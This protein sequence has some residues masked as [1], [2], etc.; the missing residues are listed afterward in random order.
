MS[1]LW[2]LLDRPRR[3]RQLYQL[4]S[5]A[6]PRDAVTVP[7]EV[8]GAPAVRIARRIGA[9][10]GDAQLRHH[11]VVVVVPRGDLD[12]EKHPASFR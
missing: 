12:A 5:E 6:E 10:M 2:A 7:S 9:D 11:P 4:K 3:Q 1:G 8:V